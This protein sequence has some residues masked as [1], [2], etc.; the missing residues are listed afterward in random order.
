MSMAVEATLHGVRRVVPLMNHVGRLVGHS[1]SEQLRHRILGMSLIV[2]AQAE[3]LHASASVRAF[4]VGLTLTGDTADRAR[5]VLSPLRELFARFLLAYRIQGRSEGA[6]AD[7]GTDFVKNTFSAGSQ[8]RRGLFS[9]A[10]ARFG[11][12]YVSGVPAQGILSGGI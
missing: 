5:K 6:C 8:H 9:R 1:V 3:F 2:A 10:S 4:L 12:L 7:A 11:D